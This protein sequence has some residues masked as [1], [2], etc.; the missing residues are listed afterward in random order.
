MEKGK[1]YFFIGLPRS[2]K[3]T[4]AK[5]W[6]KHKFDIKNGQMLWNT[7]PSVESTPRAVVSDDAIRLAVY[8][9][10]YNAIGEPMVFAIKQV[11][12][13]ALLESGHNV[14]VDDT[15]TTATSIERLLEIDPDAQYYFVDTSP[16]VCKSRATQSGQADM[17]PVIDRFADN[18]KLYVQTLRIGVEPTFIQE[19]RTKIKD[20]Q[21]FYN[22]WKNLKNANS[23][24]NAAA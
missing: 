13:R 22:E 21:K 12:I 6:L 8:D 11:M 24:S 9:Q 14:L 10:R 5:Q 2:G 23:S 19:L 1:L 16:E 17:A 18:M 20:Y 7:I 4:L 3:S 15:H